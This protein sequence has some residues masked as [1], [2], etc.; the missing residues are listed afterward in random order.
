MMTHLRRDFLE[1][2]CD[3]VFLLIGPG[4]WSKK[5]VRSLNYG[6]YFDDAAGNAGVGILDLLGWG[7]K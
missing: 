3:K 1:K 2:M 6:P 7:K 4:D 5:A